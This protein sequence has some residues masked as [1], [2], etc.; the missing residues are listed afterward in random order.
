MAG[1]NQTFGSA[2]N[3][4]TISISLSGLGY[5]SKVIMWTSIL[6]DSALGTWIV[7]KIA[8]GSSWWRDLHSIVILPLW[9]RRSHANAI[10]QVSLQKKNLAK[11]YSIIAALQKSFKS[12]S[13]YYSYITTLLRLQKGTHFGNKSISFIRARKLK[14]L[15]LVLNSDLT[16]ND[17][18]GIFL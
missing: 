12:L 18:S 3:N 2:F 10:I 7:L 14:I 1:A 13:W 5:I 16:F 4:M 17:L 6:V 9:I 11:L 8:S 15:A